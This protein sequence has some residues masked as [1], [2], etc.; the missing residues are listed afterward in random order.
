MK[1][2][3]IF[4]FLV[5]TLVGLGILSLLHFGAQL[6]LPVATDGSAL[7]VKQAATDPS[8]SMLGAMLAGLSENFSSPLSH[9]F[10]QLL[11]I[12]AASRLLGGLFARFG[13]P[14]VIGEM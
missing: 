2:T 10:L 7:P 4:Y 12:I 3:A 8:S 14:S 11:V 6:P 13:Q 9:L 1:R 5:L